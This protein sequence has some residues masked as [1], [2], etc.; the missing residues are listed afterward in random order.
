MG[1][2]RL[3]ALAGGTYDALAAPETSTLQQLQ[4]SEGIF[5]A[6]KRSRAMRLLLGFPHPD[7][8]HLELSFPNVFEAS[9][10]HLGVC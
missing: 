7:L 6:Q 2:F 4:V 9:V 8:H 1:L 10:L 5:D 3:K